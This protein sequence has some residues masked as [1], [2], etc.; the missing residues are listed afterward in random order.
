[1]SSLSFGFKAQLANAALAPLRKAGFASAGIQSRGRAGTC[2]PG[3]RSSSGTQP[4]AP[5]TGPGA[6][7]GF[8]SIVFRKQVSQAW[9][10]GG[11]MFRE[12]KS[13]SLLK[14]RKK[15]GKKKK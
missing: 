12:V 4:A 15:K 10:A 1:M 2:R 6:C 14:K 8:Q 9:K 5:G 11:E 7:L 3:G 13:L